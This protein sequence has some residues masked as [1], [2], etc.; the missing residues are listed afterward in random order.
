MKSIFFLTLLVS[1]SLNAQVLVSQAV[2]DINGRH[3]T[4]RQV[5][6]TSLMS[7]CLKGSCAKSKALPRSVK[8][9][10]FATLLSKSIFE[11]L[12]FFE[13]TG[14]FEDYKPISNSQINLIMNSKVARQYQFN[15]QE[16]LKTYRVKALA[17]KYIDF[18]DKNLSVYITKAEVIKYYKKNKKLYP[19]GSVK[20]HEPAIKKYLWLKRKRKR[21]E[22]WVSNMQSKYKV[23]QL[24]N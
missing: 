24:I 16:V 21:V 6:L 22:D 9:E 23:K 15:Q 17:K 2:A 11:R 19:E 3:L 10:S 20:D 13:S 8:S 1:L 18:K 5:I 12:A 14:I 4:S 7:I